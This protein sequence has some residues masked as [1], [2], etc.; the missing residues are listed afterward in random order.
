M[1]GRFTL[2]QSAE[3]LAQAF[4]IQSLPD[5]EQQYNIAPTQ[6]VATVSSNSDKERKFQQLHWGLI[7]SWAK[8][9]GIGVKLINA[10][11]ETVAEK[12][13]FRAAF[14][15]RRCLVMAD[16]FYEWQ[17]QGKTTKSPASGE[18]LLS[19]HPEKFKK[20]PF[21]FRLQ[22]A[23]PFAFAGLWE[24]WESPEGKKI[25][26]CTILTTVANELLQPIH[27]RMPVILS[28]KDYDLWLDPQV[29]TLEPLQQI[30]RPYPTEKMSAYPVSTLVNNPKHDSSECI[31]PY[32]AS[33]V[34]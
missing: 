21:Y 34:G 26:S 24:Q 16:G 32:E 14:K 9:T 33:A 17:Q 30:L 3:T 10:R 8:D 18:K 28:P 31:T 5:L 15:H 29:Q 19:S 20:Q 4:E 11:S 22:D 7:P 13:S 25:A 23:Q 2:S 6:V 27:D 1:C 12:P